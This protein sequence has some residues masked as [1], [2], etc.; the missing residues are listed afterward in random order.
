V[1]DFEYYE[2]L[3]LLRKNR[4]AAP[5]CPLCL[6]LGSSRTVMGVVPERLPPLRSGQGELVTVF[7]FAH[8]GA[9]IPHSLLNLR[10][11][12][13]EGFRPRWVV[14]ELLPAW[15]TKPDP[16][17]IA[18]HSRMSEVPFLLRYYP[19]RKVFKA[20][21]RWILEAAPRVLS[22]FR[23]EE[24]PG[25]NH[26][27]PLGGYP[28]LRSEVDARTRS[29]KTAIAYSYLHKEIQGFHV[30][31]HIDKALRDFVTLCEHEGI[32]LVIVV[33]PESSLIRSWYTPTGKRLLSEYLHSTHRELGVLVLNAA[34]WLEDEDMYDGHHPTKPGAER[35]TARLAKELFK[36]W[37]AGNRVASPS[38]VA[39][40]TPLP[41]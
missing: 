12:L 17:I 39:G 19:L 7:N 8:F 4:A 38:C 35:L 11:L 1:L 15:L 9:S 16:N 6:V 20:R 18:C 25:V 27:D 33:T 3:A 10:R 37:F 41:E 34:D 14:L 13:R 29:E 22:A 21:A 28:L 23:G 36:P 2:R 30:D 31:R 24:L 32:E 26:L 40:P 5:E